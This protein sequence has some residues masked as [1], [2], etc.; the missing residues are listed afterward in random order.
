MSSASP[1]GGAGAAAR[2]SGEGRRSQALAKALVETERRVDALRE[3][4]DGLRRGREKVFRAPPA[5]WIQERLAGMQ[6]V[7]ERRTDGSPLLLYSLLGQIRLEPAQGE[8][9]RPYYVARSSLDTLA[10]LA[11]LASQD[12]PEA[13][14]NS[15]QWWR[16]R[17]SNPG[18]NDVQKTRLRA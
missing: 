15:L 3:E 17:E 13:G 2:S 12:S 16:R 8:I 14:S 7:L 4:L 9:G 18:P 1:R 6:E 5:E 10:L 11:P